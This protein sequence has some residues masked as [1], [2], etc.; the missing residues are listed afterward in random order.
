MGEL[1]SVVGERDAA[2]TS[3]PAEASA[4]TTGRPTLPVALLCQPIV[5]T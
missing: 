1:N 2:V 4:A 3:N 5:L